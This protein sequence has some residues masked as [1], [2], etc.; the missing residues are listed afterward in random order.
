M[1]DIFDHTGRVDLDL[2]NRRRTWRCSLPKRRA[3]F[4][5]MAA[6]KIEEAT[7]ERSSLRRPTST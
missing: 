4:E 6:A 2:D 1:V 7:D 3:L 5:E